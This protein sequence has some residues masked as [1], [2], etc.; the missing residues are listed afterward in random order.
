MEMKKLVLMATLFSVGACNFNSSTPIEM[1]PKIITV[2]QNSVLNLPADQITFKLVQANVLQRNCI[3]CHSATANNKGVSNSGD[4][5]L[6]TYENV[7]KKLKEIRHELA[8]KDMPPSENPEF[9]LTD[10]Q[11]QFV[12]SWI[13]AG[14]KELIDS[15]QQPPL[16]EEPPVVEPPVVNPPV[17]NPPTTVVGGKIYFAEVFEKV[18]STNCTGC[19]SVSRGSVAGLDLETYQQTIDNIENVR[20]FVADGSMPTRRGTPLTDV[21]KKLIADWIQQGAL[22]KAP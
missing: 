8:T 7:I 20:D 12:L 15:P 11:N 14:A 1:S 16:P 9:A 22:E 3:Y 17:V 10:A 4:V 13:A 2:N 6:E 19:H 21:Q 5:N 18:I